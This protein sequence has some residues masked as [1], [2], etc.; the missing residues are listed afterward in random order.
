M[1]DTFGKAAALITKAESTTTVR[2]SEANIEMAHTLMAKHAIDQAMLG[3]GGSSSDRGPIGETSFVLPTRAY[4]KAFLGLLVTVSEANHCWVWI[5]RSGSLSVRHSGLSKACLVGFEANRR[6]T[7]LLFDAVC[8]LVARKLQAREV[9]ELATAEPALAR[10]ASRARLVA[11]GM[12]ARLETATEAVHKE[13]A[14]IHGSEAVALA[15][16][17]VEVALQNWLDQMY[18]SNDAGGS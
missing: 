14:A 2:E 15:L 13:A 12:A 9:I 8:V 7:K 1:G 4:H 18:P 10:P 3:V 6:S 11:D 17:D 16:S 5:Y